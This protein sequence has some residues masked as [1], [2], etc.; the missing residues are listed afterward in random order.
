MLPRSVTQGDISLTEFGPTH[1]KN[2]CFKEKSIL[3]LTLHCGDAAPNFGAGSGKR[4]CQVKTMKAQAVANRNRRWHS[5]KGRSIIE[6]LIVVTI[7][8]I[9]TS[10]ALPQM[11][12][13]RRLMRSAT[14]PREIASQLRFT[15]QQAMSQRQAFTFQYDD[16]TKQITIFNHNNVGNSTTSCNM[17][18][19]AV[20]AASGYPNTA[21]TTTLLTIP[22]TGSGGLP[23]SEVSYG[24]PNGISSTALSDTTTLT[25]LSSNKVYVTFQS[26]GTVVDTNGNPTNRTLFFYNNQ[27]ATQ[28]AAAVSVL[29]AS[30]RIKVWRYDTSANKY[31]E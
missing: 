23:A 16:S 31:A 14:L 30:G 15:R 24:I 26:D 5:A 21:C 25:S 7:A 18:G 20:L 12:S 29:G 9:L 19:A 17:S 10:V 6:T 22:L 28:T 4:D 1:Q 11:M 2:P 3:A 27:V 13:A 8:A